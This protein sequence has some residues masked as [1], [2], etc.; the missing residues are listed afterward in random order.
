MFRYQTMEESIGQQL[1]QAREARNLSLKKVTQA[2]RIQAHL[3]E[4]M[5]A[6]DFESMPSP[7]QARAFLRIYAKYLDLSLDDLIARQQPV[8]EDTP[9]ELNS[10]QPALDP[11]QEL[12]EVSDNISASPP[13]NEAGVGKSIPRNNK[14]KGFIFRLLHLLPDQK[15]PSEPVV[16]VKQIAPSE[17]ENIADSQP[18]T[19]LPDEEESTAENPD[20]PV[21]TDRITSDLHESDLIFARIGETLRRHREALSLTLDEIEN[22]TH[23]R[24]HYL[25][26]LEAGD[27]DHLPSSVQARGM[28]NNYAH[29]LDMD[30]DAILFQ[31]AEGLQV[32]RLER[33]PE[34]MGKKQ[35][36]NGKN[37]SRNSLSSGSRRLLSIDAIVGGGLVLILLVFA[38]WGTTRVIA[39]RSANTPQPTAQPISD[40]LVALP[41]QGTPTP[42]P[43]NG[44][45]NGTELPPVSPTAIVTVPVTGQGAVKIVLIALEQA[46]VRV[47]ADGKRV[48]D[49]RISAGTAYPFD[50]N[51]QIEVLTGNGAAVSI[52]FNQ[53]DLGAMGGSGEVVDRIYTTNAILNP[54]A[55]YTPTPTISPTPSMTPRQSPTPRPSN[56]P[57]KPAMPQSHE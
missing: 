34:P 50:G 44:A 41:R 37:P 15:E 11:S 8:I 23:V 17:N 40:I 2:T 43:T 26:A 56:T 36:A 42:M 32:Q 47:T 28:L 33:Q 51:N 5:E 3:L 12:E 21:P 57:Q 22:H 1:K 48:F 49:G 24:K 55:T 30:L 38:I 45:I 14:I 6:D 35:T 18:A 27:F 10:V 4:A 9:G 31:F 54:T 20:M 39:L 53:T 46:F 52:L 7:M 13:D 16:S 29:F 19:S 25:Q